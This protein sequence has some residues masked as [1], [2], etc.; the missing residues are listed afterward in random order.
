[1][2]SS[3]TVNE[4]KNDLQVSAYRKTRHVIW[5]ANRGTERFSK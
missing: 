3:D 1:M 5:S 4:G 2:E